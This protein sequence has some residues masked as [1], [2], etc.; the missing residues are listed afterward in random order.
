MNWVLTSSTH[1]SL[2]DRIHTYVSRDLR[3]FTLFASG[4]SPETSIVT[5]YY[6]TV[7]RI[8]GCHPLYPSQKVGSWVFCSHPRTVLLISRP[9]DLRRSDRLRQRS[10]RV[11]SS[12]RFVRI[13]KGVDNVGYT[14][15]RDYLLW[16]GPLRMSVLDRLCYWY[17]T[18]IYSS[19][20]LH[21]WGSRLRDTYILRVT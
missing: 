15:F 6:F 7:E 13:L 3:R 16:V 14:D 11:T 1:T 10:G 21:L 8:P 12:T 5:C 17:S 9:D 18:D 19:R 4:G 20:T 2:R